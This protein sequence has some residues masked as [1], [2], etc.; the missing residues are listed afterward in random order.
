VSLEPIRSPRPLKG[1]FA[2]SDLLA[3]LKRERAADRARADRSLPGYA[4]PGPIAC[5][6]GTEPGTPTADGARHEDLRG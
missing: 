4:P 2:G 1:R 3:I 5:L 6:D